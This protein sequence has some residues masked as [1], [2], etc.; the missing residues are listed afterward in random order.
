MFAIAL[1]AARR[2]FFAIAD[3]DQRLGKEARRALRSEGLDI[4]MADW[5]GRSLATAES[6]GVPNSILPRFEER[7]SWPNAK[8]RWW[9]ASEARGTPR[10]NGRRRRQWTRPARGAPMLGIATEAAQDV[11]IESAGIRSQPADLVPGLVGAAICGCDHATKQSG[12]I[13]SLP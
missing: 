1:A 7:A 8:A 5:R 3:S 12:T 11:A 13:F 10:R 6:G 4:V 2:A 9:Q